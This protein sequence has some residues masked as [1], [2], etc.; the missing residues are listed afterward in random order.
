MWKCRKLI[1]KVSTHLLCVAGEISVQKLS[2]LR[3][4]CRTGNRMTAVCGS[5]RARCKCLCH[6]SRCTD[7]SDRHAAAHCFCHGNDI[8]LYTI[9]HIRHHRTG[10]AP[11]CLNLIQQKKNA[12]LIT[13]LTKSCHELRCCR[14]DTALALYRLDHDTDRVIGYSR[15]EGVQIIVLRICKSGSHITKTDLAGIVRLT[16]R[17]HCTK[18]TSMERHFSGNDVVFIWTIFLNTIFSCH[19]DHCLICL[20]S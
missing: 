18:G 20:S 12:L 1:H 16:G 8:R 17:T 3:K 19:L 13:E 11:S 4:R 10:S 2:D 6:L 14:I 7:C 5:V 15:L 9:I